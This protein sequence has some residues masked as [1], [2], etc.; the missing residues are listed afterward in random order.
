MSRDDQSHNV[1]MTRV[2]DA[3]L[4]QVWKAWVDPAYV[5]Q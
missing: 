1:V 2:F 5:K 4:E 3:P